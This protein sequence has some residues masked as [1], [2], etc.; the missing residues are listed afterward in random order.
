MHSIHPKIVNSQVL[1]CDY[2][3]LNPTAIAPNPYPPNP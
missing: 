3:D 1:A 2:I